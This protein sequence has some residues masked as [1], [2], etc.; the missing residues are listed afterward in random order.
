MH[1]YFS[2]LCLSMLHSQKF[3]LTYLQI[4]Q[5]HHRLCW[6]CM[7]CMHQFFKF[8]LLH[9]F[10]PSRVL[11]VFF[12]KFLGHL[13]NIL[14]LVTYSFVKQVIMFVLLSD[15]LNVWNVYESFCY[16]LL[17]LVISYFAYFFMCVF[18]FEWVMLVILEK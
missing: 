16:L 15:N 5:V 9:I 10:I 18:I 17:F 13:K 14:F 7:N 11:S 2:S 4:Y 1:S 12:F 8:L 3:L 6:I